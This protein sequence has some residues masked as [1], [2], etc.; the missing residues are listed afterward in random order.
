MAC[1]FNSCCQQ[2]TAISFLSLPEFNKI[3]HAS[4]E[5]HILVKISHKFCDT[6]Q[7]LVH[8]SISLTL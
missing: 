5:R 4:S 6:L 7:T 1:N 8:L 2:S 3:F